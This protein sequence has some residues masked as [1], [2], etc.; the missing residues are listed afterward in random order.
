ME[1]KSYRIQQ[2][3][4]LED[5]ANRI[6]IS[7]EKLQELNPTMKTFKNFWGTETYAVVNQVLDVPTNTN[8][9]KSSLSIDE[10][11]DKRNNE[12]V[13]FDFKKNLEEKAA[14]LSEEDHFL[15]NLTF[16]Q[17][18]R[19]RCEQLNTTKV[20]DRI[21]FHYNT[22]KQYLLKNNVVENISKVQLEEYLYKINPDNLGHTIEAMKK[23]EYD[24]ENV[25]FKKHK[26]GIEE[27]LNYLEI[28]AKWNDFIPLLKKT[29]FY[30]N[31]EKLNA[32]AAQE[33]LNVG[34][35]EFGKE[36]NLRKTYDKNL[37]FHVLFNNF[38]PD[39]GAYPKLNFISQ[40]FVN[41]P[42]ELD[43]QH[44][45]VKEDDLYIEYRTVGTLNRDKI[46][47]RI[48]EEQYNKFYKPIIEYPF[49]KYGYEYRIRRTVEKKTGKI[50]N[51]V[52][53]LKEEVKNNYQFIT[54][55][56]L[57]EVDI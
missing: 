41:I 20:E 21:S 39:N 32:N 48:L 5:L 22:K 49:S 34:N 10:K 44:S 18:A 56:D 28:K 50:T 2:E 53:M 37:L 45:I 15:K 6:G 46:D 9:G 40:I 12:F 51:A 1:Y 8:A 3:E 27:I 19:Y 25:V 31:L 36:E 47:N 42:I 16:D 52:A 11:K 55:F 35:I 38:K 24:K 7:V 57:K 43:L 54:Q 17:Q 13:D 14:S 26:N 23:L 30:T 29:D 4:K 33:I